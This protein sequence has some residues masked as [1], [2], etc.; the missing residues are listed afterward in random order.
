MSW[1]M[2][3]YDG[4]YGKVDSEYFQTKPFSDKELYTCHKCGEKA[5]E[6]RT[7]DRISTVKIKWKQNPLNAPTTHYFRKTLYIEIC[8][9]C[10]YVYTEEQI[11]ETDAEGSEV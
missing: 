11:R 7:I 8:W 3:Y 5:H 2:K 1:N 10:G 4:K 9:S 6:T